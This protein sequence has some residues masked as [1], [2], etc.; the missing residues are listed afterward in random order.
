VIGGPPWNSKFREFQAQLPFHFV[1]RPLGQDDPLCIHAIDNVFFLPTWGQGGNLVK[2]ISIFAKI[3]I[4][5]DVP[6]FLIAGCLTFGVLG[7]AMS[8]LD[9]QV[10]VPNIEFLRN[11]VKGNDF[12]AV[13]ETHRVGGFVV[14]TRFSSTKPLV[15][16]GRVEQ[17]N[18]FQIALENAS[19]YQKPKA[20]RQ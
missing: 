1:P 20:N 7:A 16:L 13:F 3:H 6:V 4:E 9:R 14:P 8:F 2:D 18:E 10:A 17:A 19:E 12:I 15:L 11:Y 5:R